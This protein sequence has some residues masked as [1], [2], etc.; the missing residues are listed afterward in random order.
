MT[1]VLSHNLYME[2]L[3][4]TSSEKLAILADS[5]SSPPIPSLSHTNQVPPAILLKVLLHDMIT[6]DLCIAKSNGHFT[7]LILLNLS[8]QQEE[9]QL[10]TFSYL[11]HSLHLIPILHT[12]ALKAFF[13]SFSFV[14]LNLSNLC[15]WKFP[16]LNLYFF[17]PD[18]IQSYGFKYHL[19]ANDSQI[20]L[21]VGTFPLN[22]SLI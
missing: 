12:S 7:V 13:S 22:S 20:L 11:K 17:V 3:Q 14:V 19:F 4:L 6:S 10:I 5:N 9:T 21:Q 2:N 15:T 1:T 8:N 18:L 16:K